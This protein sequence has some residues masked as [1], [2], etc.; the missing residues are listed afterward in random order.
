LGVSVL[1]RESWYYQNRTTQ[2]AIDSC[3]QVIS[4]KSPTA[5]QA[6]GFSAPV[7]VSKGNVIF[8]GAT[9]VKVAEELGLV[10]VPA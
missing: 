6:M 9:R 4:R 7:L 3:S 5:I 10:E 8:D 2:F 1:I